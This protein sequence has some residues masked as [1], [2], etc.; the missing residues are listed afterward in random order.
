MLVLIRFKG[1]GVFQLLDALLPCC[2]LG[3]AIGKAGCFFSGD[4]CYGPPADPEV[5]PWA[6]S[7]PNAADP[8]TVPVHPTPIYEGMLSFIVFLLALV[9]FP[10]PRS[11]GGDGR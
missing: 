7:F 3:H 6:M 10:L 1:V 2:L 8:T 9:V 11:A 4:G 5:V